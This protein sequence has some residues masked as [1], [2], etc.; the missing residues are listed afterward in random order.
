MFEAMRTTL[1]RRWVEHDAFGLFQEV[2]R[3]AKAFYEWRAE[4]GPVS[5]VVSFDILQ[6]LTLFSGRKYLTRLKPP[7]SFVVNIYTSPYYVG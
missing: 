2:M 6:S 4:E 1:D 5:L 7:S 3:G